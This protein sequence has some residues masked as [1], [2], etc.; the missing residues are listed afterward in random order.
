MSREKS[1]T[2]TVRPS[3]SQKFNKKLEAK[4]E[5][6]NNGKKEYRVGYL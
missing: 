1:I 6:S 3:D 2:W 4:L 5:T